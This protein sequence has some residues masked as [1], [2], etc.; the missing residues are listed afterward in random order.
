MI[1]TE[2]KEKEEVADWSQSSDEKMPMV[3][4]KLSLTDGEENQERDRERWW[5]K[6]RERGEEMGLLVM[7]R[8]GAVDGDDD[9]DILPGEEERDADAG[10]KRG[11]ML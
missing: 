3:V 2:A 11:E 9:G 5:S 7:V 1:Q 4:M 6:R 8:R 10:E